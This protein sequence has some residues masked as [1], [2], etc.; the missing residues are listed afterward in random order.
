MPTAFQV[1]TKWVEFMSGTGADALVSWYATVTQLL[2]PVAMAL[3]SSP[4][5]TATE[6]T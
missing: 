4:S 5:P 6:W 3:A 2:F 1:K